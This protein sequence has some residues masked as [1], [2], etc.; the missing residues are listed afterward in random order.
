MI[1]G[2]AT[3]LAVMMLAMA[4]AALIAER[5]RRSGFV[6]GIWSLSSGFA[7]ALS[8][9]LAAGWT[10]RAVLVAGLIGLWALRLGR[11][12][13][14]RSFAHVGDDPRYAALRR[15]WG[16]AAP[17]RMFLFLQTQ[18]LAGWLLALSATAMASRPGPV[19]W[20]DGLG[21]FLALA[22]ICGEGLADRTLNRFRREK[23]GAVCDRGLWGWSRHPNY[24]FEWLFWVGLALTG[25]GGLDLRSAGALL[26]PAI[27]Y[28]LLV[29]VSGIP[30]LEAHMAR[31]RG[32]AFAAYRRRVSAFFPWPSRTDAQGESQR[33]R[34]R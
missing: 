17:R 23:P 8:I 28:A 25:V 33:D 2:A 5:T 34:S 18:A 6:D 9:G 24:F 14:S 32:E 3:A 29:H 16:E 27:M 20:Q 31:S 13:L 12:L 22:A 21:L 19:D 7:G 11:H 1:T 10:G 30:P 4:A 15:E 26:A